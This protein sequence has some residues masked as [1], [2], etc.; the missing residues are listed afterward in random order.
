[1]LVVLILI[2]AESFVR[3]EDW[4]K[5]LRIPVVDYERDAEELRKNPPKDED[6][7]EVYLK[8]FD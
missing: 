7:K 4:T 3:K 1:M 6:K 8:K 2:S 5:E